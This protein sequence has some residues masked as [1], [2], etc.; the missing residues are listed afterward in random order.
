M[1]DAALC[2]CGRERG[3]DEGQCPREEVSNCY[4]LALANERA[5]AEK[6]E[7]AMHD[8]R[9]ALARAETALSL[10]SGAL[11]DTGDIPVGP[12]LEYGARV[13]DLTAQRDVLRAQLPESMKDCTIVFK[14]CARGHG[15]LTATNW[16]QHPCLFCERDALKAEVSSLTAEMAVCTTEWMP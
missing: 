14:E 12:A 5:R 10:V 9:G 13:R 15:E 7:A 16:V 6:A 3:L 11:A 4:A 2:R 8:A 1:S